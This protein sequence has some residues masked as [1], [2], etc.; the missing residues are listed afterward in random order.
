[1]RYVEGEIELTT[2]SS[3]QQDR[4]AHSKLNLDR[5]LHIHSSVSHGLQD[6]CG[7]RRMYAFGT[8]ARQL[9]LMLQLQTIKKGA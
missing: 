6:V 5:D 8:E 1:M 2:T 3:R 7:H 4:S 9:R